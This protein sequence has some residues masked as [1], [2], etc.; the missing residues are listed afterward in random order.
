VGAASSATLLG[1]YS[2][3]AQ[4]QDAVTE[5]VVTGSRIIRQDFI[6]NSPIA[7]VNAEALTQ[8]G[9]V[10]LD[11]FL[12][13]LPS[14]NPAG[15]TTS[16]NPG[17]N[18][19]SNVNLRGLGSNRNLVLIDGRRP[20]VS[21]SDQTVDLNTIPQALIESIEVI[22]GGAGAAYG[23]DALAGA[24]NL[25]LKKNFEGIA[26]ETSISD[27]T[28]FNDAK[29]KA[30]S[31][32]IGGNFAEDRGNVIIGFEWADREGMIKSQRDFSAQATATTSFLPEG[33]YFSSGNAPTQAAV[34]AV[35]ATYGVAAGAVP[36]AGSFIGFNLDGTLFSRG[37]FNSPLQ[38]QNF[39]Y[40]NDVSVNGPLFPDVYSYNFDSVNILTLPLERRSMMTKL[41]Y[42]W[43][44]GTEI[45]ANFGYTEYTSA[46]ALAPTPIPTVP[47]RPTGEA[48]SAGEAT[49][50]F[51]TPMSTGV[52]ALL[53]VP[54]T[55]PFIPAQFRTLLAT[56]TGDNAN[57]IGSGAT[58]PFLMRQ[59]TLDVG[60]RQSNYENTVVQYLVGAKG[61]LFGDN[62]R[63]EAYA[64]EGRTEIDEAQTGNIDTQRLLGLLAAADGGVSQCAG[65][66]N[67]FGRQGISAACR[68]F[69]EVSNTVS[70][71]LKQQIV[72]AY[73]SGDIAELP[74]GPLSVVLGTEYRGFRYG[75]D[76]GSAGG[77]ISGFNV[78]DPAGGTNSFKDI[79]AEALFPLV[80]DASWA[81]SVELTVGLRFS[82]SQ[83]KNLITDEESDGSSDTAYK[84]E[85]S[86][87]IND[88]VR[89]RG[90]YQRAVRAPN[91]GELFDGG[92]SNPQYFDPCSVT[93]DARR[94]ANGAALTTLCQ[95]AGQLG[96]GGFGNAAA[97]YVQTPGTQVGL[98][99]SANSAADPETSDSFTLGA[100]FTE[101][102]GWA[103][104]RATIDYYNISIKDPLI[105]IDTNLLI[106]DC[107][108][109]YGNN[110]MYDPNHPNCVGIFRAGGD[111]LGYD[112]LNDPDGF[113]PTIN[114]GKYSTDG[115][116]IQV[117]WGRDVGPGKLQ[118]Q[119]YMNYLLSWKQRSSDDLPN[120]D[121]AGTVSFFGA[122]DGL[123]GSFP[124][125]KANLLGRYSIGKFDIDGR[126]RFI[127]SMENRASVL[128][129][130]ETSFTGAES[131]TYFD[132]GATWRASDNWSV[133]LGV[134]NVFDQEPAT[135]RPNVQSGTDPSLYD[136]VGR[137]AYVQV[138]AKF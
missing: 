82:D 50:A 71:T 69:L 28:E 111:I 124:E 51:L 137:R 138:N 4:D 73:V 131:I 76:P 129:P 130:G 99:L 49:S 53:I 57:I 102:F 37:V 21:A 17:N 44:N 133:R 45:F 61:K 132:L 5:V 67:P 77:P 90:S 7:T 96:F 38:V 12:N 42:Q 65:G 62:W 35:F 18:G 101:P 80:Q 30:I 87:G 91:F 23:A 119:L 107:Y 47:I 2:A 95:N 135:Y 83:F 84:A 66:F 25:R 126:L 40:P 136:I 93:S 125:I 110:P 15:G 121:F 48:R 109:Y 31:L 89:L 104:L 113:F 116:D 105:S 123:G 32:A 100:V 39:R 127:D 6:S 78:Q 59:R 72:Q 54:V 86:W 134:N 70:T 26:L 106:A 128:Y 117:D 112:N 52:N 55:N 22:T 20:M 56:R 34:D 9:D 63:W 58:E 43:D 36:A 85:L 1:S 16:N 98:T 103:N 41:N 64:S 97:T 13:T 115:I 24:V 11:T 8:N 81:Q 46:S 114:G 122:G 27:S 120:F 92:G 75:F 74:A 19:Q 94:G 88:I 60:L 79:F 3:Y 108:N 14:V 68:E 10:T 118:L 33:L 29:E